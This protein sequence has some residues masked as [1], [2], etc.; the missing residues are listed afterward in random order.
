MASISKIKL[1]N[2]ASYEIKD[3]V[4]R[5]LIAGGLKYIVA[6][7]GNSMPVVSN[8]PAGVVVRWEG[9][10]YT[11]I[12]APEDAELG[13]F[14]LV[15]HV[16]PK[17]SLDYYAEYAVVTIDETKKWEKIGTTDIDLSSLG[18]LAWKDNVIL[19]KGDGDLVLGSDSAF[20][21]PLTQATVTPSKSDVL[22]TGA[23]FGTTMTNTKKKLSAT[24]ANASVSSETE[25]VIKSVSIVSNKLDIDT[26]HDTPST[27]T[28][29]LASEGVT[30]VASV[31][32]REIPNV[33]SAGT[34]STWN[35]AL[36]TGDDVETL[37][38]TGANSIAPTL[39]T[40]ISAS[41]ITTEAK[42]FV[43]G[44]STEGSG[45]SVVIGLVEGTAKNIAVGT[46]S[47][48]GEGAS[49][50]IDV[51]TTGFDVIKSVSVNKQPDITIAYNVDG[52]VEVMVESTA[53]TAIT[54]AAKVEALTGATV[55]V[56][57]TA[58]TVTKDEVSV[59]KYGD[60]SV[61]AE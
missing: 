53:A 55:S 3:A 26:V 11:G 61:S 16:D 15:K 14:Y 34:A 57:Q 22:G 45:E 10:D 37:I 58:I 40:A 52:D 4:A 41:D 44:L 8:I 56:P 38:I 32:A 7:D 1:P 46:V 24:A 36:G 29:H 59:A 35:F 27:N 47:A 49:V 39:G 19:S 17:E 31:T 6:W 13:G 23:T 2:G 33:T 60:L 42:T 51:S 12:L 21:L 25:N 30:G 50:G 5:E 43:T 54:D 9:T 20:N 48:N 18:D 28:K